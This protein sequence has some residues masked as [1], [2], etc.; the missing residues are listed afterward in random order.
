M[1]IL[2]A[3]DRF[4]LAEMPAERLAMVRILVGIYAV[5]FLAVR[6]PHLMSYA[7]YASNFFQPVGLATLLDAPLPAW[8][9]KG[10]VVVTLLLSVTFLTGFRFRIT[11]PLFAAVQLWV[12]TYSNSFGKILH[13]DNMLVV[14]V[15]ALGL[16]PAADALSLDSRRRGT[17]PGPSGRYGWAVRLMCLLC[18]G[19][20]LLAGVAKVRNSGMAFIVGDTL[21]NYV[22]FDN[23]RKIE[24][25]SIYSPLGAALLPYG[26]LF[27]VLAALSVVLELAA[28]LALVH[29]RIAAV[30]AAGIWGFHV[31]V[32]ALMA[33]AFPYPLSGVAFAPLFRVDRLLRWKPVHRLHVRLSRPA[34]G[35]G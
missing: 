10:L 27:S 11:G 16:A 13:T 17:V 2:R 28:P 21:R 3:V 18:I 34:S 35:A 30:W 1:G 9:A 12:L 7:D 31:G 5:I 24:L 25:G 33:I 26:A 19:A 23:V 8:L 4:W 15:I 29:R 22:A 20:Y 32:L 6:T 14:H